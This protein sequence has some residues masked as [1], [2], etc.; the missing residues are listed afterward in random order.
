MAQ[1]SIF[2][3]NKLLSRSLTQSRQIA[4][5]MQFQ[6]RHFVQAIKKVYHPNK[7]MNDLEEQAYGCTENGQYTRALYGFEQLMQKD[8][9]CARYY[10][11]WGLTVI[12]YIDQPS[13]EMI[14]DAH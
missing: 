14:H 6:K 5:Q 10:F 4:N 13:P 11:D 12:R 1:K 9:Q 8:P 3:F 7:E 2:N